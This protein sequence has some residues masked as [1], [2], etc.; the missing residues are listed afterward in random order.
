MQR[1]QP[2]QVNW[3]VYEGEINT[4]T[5]CVSRYVH[6]KTIYCISFKVEKVCDYRNELLFAIKHSLLHGN[7]VW[8]NPIAQGQHRY[9]TGNVSIDP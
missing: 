1:T 5:V 4:Y 9:F 2:M 8:S 3:L 6:T 7:L